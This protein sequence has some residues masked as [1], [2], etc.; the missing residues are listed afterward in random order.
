[1]PDKTSVTQELPPAGKTKNFKTTEIARFA[2]LLSTFIFVHQ[3]NNMRLLKFVH[4]FSCFLLIGLSSFSQKYEEVHWTKQDEYQFLLEKSAKATMEAILTS[5][6]GAGLTAI[7][8][9]LL[10]QESAISV[11]M[12]NGWVSATPNNSPKRVGGLVLTGLGGSAVLTGIIVFVN[13][14]KL[15]KQANLL[16]ADHSISFLHSTIHVPSI[17]VQFPF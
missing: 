16:V 2:Q 10:S 15:K 5:I 4:L 14:V 7:G 11:S 12:N 6:G 8:I 13:A 17:G 3:P 1:M 9:H